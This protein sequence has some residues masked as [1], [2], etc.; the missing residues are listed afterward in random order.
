M[1]SEFSYMKMSR[2]F[3]RLY[4]EIEESSSDFGTMND[5][6]LVR[7]FALYALNGFPFFDR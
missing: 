7:L 4:T 2:Q 6:E 5:F 3:V 1:A